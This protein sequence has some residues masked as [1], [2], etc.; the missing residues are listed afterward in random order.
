MRQFIVSDLHGNGNVYKSIMSYL[1]NINLKEK[2]I[3]YINGDLIDR[4]IESAEMLLDVKRRMISG[5]FKIEYLG[6]NHELMMYQMFSKR[7]K[8]ITMYDDIWFDNGGWVTDYGLEDFLKTKESIL[9]LV[10][11]IANL[12]IYHKFNEKI[13]NKSIVLVHAAC[14]IEV[15]D[16]CHLKINDESN[17]EYMVWARENDQFLPFKCRIGN[18]N[19]F[20]I[21]G[22]SPNNNMY[23]CEYHQDWNYLNIDGGC[24]QYVSGLFDYNHVPLVEVKDGY[25]KIVTFNNNNEIIYGNYFVNGGFIPF[26]IE[27]LEKERKCLDSNFKPKRLIH[28]SDGIVGYEDWR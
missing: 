27:E 21:V 20:S 9:D 14:P 24:A 17:I 4:G 23:G 16:K 22:H 3:L 15:E 18:K 2:V 25:L 26:S 11:F 7:V 13:E 10:S 12:K 6:G 19:Y 5:P 28:L 8:G 1:E